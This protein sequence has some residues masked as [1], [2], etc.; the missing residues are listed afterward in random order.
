MAAPMLPC[1]HTHTSYMFVTLIV[2]LLL[3]YVVVRLWLAHA[4]RLTRGAAWDGGVRRLRPEMTYTATGFSNP[5]RVVFDALF[6]PTTV[7]DTRETVGEHFRIAI[8]REREHVHLVER[9][10][11]QPIKWAAFWCAGALAAMHH[12]R[13]NAYAAYALLSLLIVL[14][15]FLLLQTS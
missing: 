2:L 13:F 7:E 12:G 9:F 5:V 6:Q 15:V 14:I 10:F 1:R 8:R 3:T 11:F 4:R